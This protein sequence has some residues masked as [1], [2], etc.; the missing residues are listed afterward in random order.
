[1]KIGTRP[2]RLC[3]FL[4]LRILR[5]R[6]L[7]HHRRVAEQNDRAAEAR[8]PENRPRRR[9]QVQAA[10]CHDA[11]GRQLRGSSIVYNDD[12]GAEQRDPASG[13]NK[14]SETAAQPGDRATGAPGLVDVRSTSV[15]LSLF[16][17]FAPSVHSVLVFAGGND[18]SSNS[19][20]LPA[21]SG[22]IAR[23]PES[24]GR[25][26]LIVSPGITRG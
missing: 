22:V 8:I 10:Q 18:S 2:E 4:A 16:G 17:I 3:P 12:E 25:G 26:V 15:T 11:A 6:T 5:R 20:T 13:Y 19:D 24:A 7:P 23:Q 14:E 1:M 21:L 9:R